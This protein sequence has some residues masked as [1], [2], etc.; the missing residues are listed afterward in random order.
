MS[1][2]AA[3]LSLT[4]N[5][6]FG[7]QLAAASFGFKSSGFDSVVGTRRIDKPSSWSACDLLTDNC[8]LLRDLS[9][10]IKPKNALI[11]PHCEITTKRCF[12]RVVFG[13]VKC[14]IEFGIRFEKA[15]SVSTSR[16]TQSRSSSIPQVNR[17]FSASIDTYCEPRVC[18][19]SG[20]FRGNRQYS[21]MLPHGRSFQ[22]PTCT[23]YSQS[24]ES[25][26]C[27]EI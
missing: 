11:F 4:G 27:F 17:S 8:S 6:G 12:F 20:N 25:V 5:I 10:A 14:F 19:K 9:L 16:L 18:F 1:W 2:F 24:S 21:V 15:W 26:P 7:K 13:V 23:V 3:C 22:F